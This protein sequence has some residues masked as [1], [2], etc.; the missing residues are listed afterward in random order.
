MSLNVCKKTR[1]VRTM[2]GLYKRLKQCDFGHGIVAA[3]SVY[4]RYFRRV[5]VRF[6][7]WADPEL[8]FGGGAK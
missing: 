2:S 5:K 4:I 3:F 1:F 7:T 6:P 8:K